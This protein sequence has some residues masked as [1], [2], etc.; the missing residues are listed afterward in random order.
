MAERTVTVNGFSKAYAMTGWRLGWA[1][2]PQP[3]IDYMSRVQSHTTSQAVTFAMHGGIAALTGDQSPVEEMR[4]AFDERRRFV[5]GR[6]GEM[7]YRCA[8]AVGAFYAFVEV[9]G[10]DVAVAARWL[11][12]ARVA[13]T[14]GSAFHAPGWLRLS[15]RGRPAAPCRGPRPGRGARLNPLFTS[16]F[17]RSRSPG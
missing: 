5:L 2:G 13:V 1:V 4:Q 10:D 3:V 9:G 7:G 14:P 12:A 15:V 11:D 16:A 17:P 8:P 6:L